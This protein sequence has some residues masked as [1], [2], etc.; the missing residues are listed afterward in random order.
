MSMAKA[1]ND[2]DLRQIRTNNGQAMSNARTGQDQMIS[3][4]KC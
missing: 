4:T 2:L 1:W 3:Q